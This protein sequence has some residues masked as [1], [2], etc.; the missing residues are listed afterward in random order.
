ME[1]LGLIVGKARG[2]PVARL[3]GELD[4]LA[5]EHVRARL[6]QLAATGS[7]V[8]DLEGLTFIDSAGLHALFG[9]AKLAA[10]QGGGVAIAVSGTSPVARVVALVHLGDVVPVRESVDAAAASLEVSLVENPG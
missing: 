2:L 9:L 4:K 5:V 8:L 10:A 3:E 7:F 1:R 6:D